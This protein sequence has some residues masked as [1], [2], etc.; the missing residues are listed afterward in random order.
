VD[1]ASW[2]MLQNPWVNQAADVPILRIR[3]DGRTLTYDFEKWT[4][5]EGRTE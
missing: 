2:P 1:Y 3:H 5:T 4:K